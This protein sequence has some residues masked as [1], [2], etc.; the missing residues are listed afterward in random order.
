MFKIRPLKRTFILLIALA[1]MLAIL[2]RYQ[3]NVTPE[4]KVEQPHTIADLTIALPDNYAFRQDDPR[5]GGRRLGKTK[6]TLS[7]YGCTLTSVAIA[8]S[9][10]LKTEI[11][12]V[13]MNRRLTKAGGF[14]KTG[15]LKWGQVGAASE[16]KL[17]AV[18]STEPSHK[19]IASC[20]QNGGYP[21][22]KIDPDARVNHWVVVV[23]KSKDD[24]YIRDPRIGKPDDAPIPLSS[25]SDYIYAA[26]CVS[27][28]N[29]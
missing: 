18:L 29:D 28:S 20:M 23:G 4:K 15:L 16:G 3:K 14:T 24:Y 21:I 22:I 2:T 9:N 11:S 6:D 1:V 26:R 12:P 25:R 7:D 19:A 27:L 13:D 5:W 8:A 10:L 17:H